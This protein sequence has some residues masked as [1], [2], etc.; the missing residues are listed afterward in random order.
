MI[1]DI[2]TVIIIPTASEEFIALVEIETVH[3]SD[4]YAKSLVYKHKIR[5]AKSCS[6]CYGLLE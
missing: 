2:Q 1:Y 3:F 5:K 4:K 6:A